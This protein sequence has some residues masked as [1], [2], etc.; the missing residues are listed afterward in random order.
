M[1]HISLWKRVLIL[2]VVVIGLVFAAPNIFYNR[3][4][5]HNDA[6]AAAAKGQALTPDQQAARAGWPDWLP[7]DIVNLGLDL[8]GGAQ[9][10]AEVNVDEVYKARVDALW[11]EFRKALAAERGTLGSIRRLNADPGVLRIQIGNADQIAEAQKIAETLNNPVSSLTGVG[12]KTLAITT[13]GNQ[14]IVQLSD[15]EKAATDDRTMQQSLEIVRRRIDAAGTREPTI[16]REGSDRILIQVPGASSAQEIKQLIGT[17]A[18]LTFN[19]VIGTSSNPNEAVGSDQE[20]LPSADQKGLYY[21]LDSVPVVTGEDLTDARPDTDQ[22][23]YP[24]VAFRFNASAARTFGDYTQNNIGKPFAIVLDKKVISAP[25]IQSHIAGGSGI[26]TGRFTVKEAT[27]LALLLRAGALPASMNFL[28]ERTI[29]PELGADSIAAGKMAAAVGAVLVVVFMIASYGTFG[30]FASLALGINIA[31]IFAIMSA[32]GGTLT[33]PGIAGIVLTMG[34]AVDANVLV[35]ERI[36]EELRNQQKAK[37]ARA[38]ELGYERAMSAIIDANV[39]TF[40]TAVILFVLGAGPVR[41]FAVTFLIGIITSVFTAIWVTRL[42]VS[43]WFARRR[44][45]ELVL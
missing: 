42:F 32:I 26:I 29:G 3:V 37:A 11:P 7:S 22:N 40:L 44:P 34:T 45:R 9:L 10:L 13:Q 41:G 17:T 33:L 20:I 25:T 28:E 23:G 4:E 2:I 27:D 24:A 38:I 5:G 30:V 14:L 21:I 19:S 8:R 1:L 16:V 36:R 43:L 39:T 12:Q 35:F 6:V 18:K 31:L 15:A